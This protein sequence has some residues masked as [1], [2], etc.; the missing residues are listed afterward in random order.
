[1]S[2]FGKGPSVEQ[3]KAASHQLRGGIADD[4]AA[5]DPGFAGANQTLI[6][7]HGLY[8]GYDR[9]TATARKQSGAAR[10]HAFMARV[11]IPGGRLSAQQYLELDRCADAYGN[12]TLRITARQAI[13]FHGV[14]KGDLKPLLSG[15]DAALLTTLAACGDVV[16]TVTTTPAPIRDA[17][18]RR[19]EADARLLSTHLL[20]QSGAYREIWLDGERVAGPDEEPLYGNVYLPRKFKIGL[21]TPA[22]NSIDVLTNDLGIIALFEGDELIGYNLALGGGL[23]M[24]HNKPR[25]Y[26][27]LATPLVFVEPDLLIPAVEAVIRLQ[28]DHGDRADRK[29]ARLKYLIDARGADW[30]VARLA[31]YVGRALAPARAMPPFRVVDHLGRHPQ[32]DGLWY[33]GIPVPSGRIEDA[34]AA[35]L[36]SALNS[37]VRRYRPAVVLTPWQD[38]ILGDLDPE[39]LEN[40]EM[41]LRA[42][43]VRLAADMLPVERWSMACPALPT[44]SLALTEA[45]RVRAPMVAEIAAALAAAG[46]ADERLSVRITGCPNGCARPYAGDIGIVGR[47]PGFYALY[48]GGDFAG[49]RLN[50]KLLDKVATADVAPTLAPLFRLF[51]AEREGGEGFGDFCHRLGLDRLRDEIA[52]GHRLDEAV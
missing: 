3:I 18:H 19:L 42:D 12:G 38:I 36:R 37:I 34:G 41:E 6:K 39:F 50:A 10:A 40:V 16:R 15:I 4:L 32:G 23:G 7:F 5:G 25:T 33:L 47:M 13:Q 52:R 35:R 31:E 8:Q 29:H 24:T 46:L 11:R 49:T 20:P 22:D 45:E 21:A 26:P 28:R 9:D 43:G 14:Y 2:A 48:V 44:C 30:I 17:V 51:A 27:R 1:M